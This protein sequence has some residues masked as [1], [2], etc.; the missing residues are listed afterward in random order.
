VHDIQ[1]PRYHSL[2]QELKTRFEVTDEEKRIKKE[3][4]EELREEIFKFTERQ[5]VHLKV[6]ELNNK[7]YS[8]NLENWAVKEIVDVSNP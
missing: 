2:N 8:V 4:K 6:E 5:E 3:K 7:I 1:G